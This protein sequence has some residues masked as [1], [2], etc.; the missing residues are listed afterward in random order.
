MR[1]TEKVIFK[2]FSKQNTL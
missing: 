1:S 2:M